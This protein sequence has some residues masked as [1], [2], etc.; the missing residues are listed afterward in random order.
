MHFY[1]HVINFFIFILRVSVNVEVKGVK[2]LYS[3][4]N[5]DS[6]LGVSSN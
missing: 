5:P 6:I 1:V 3:V 2:L 4:L